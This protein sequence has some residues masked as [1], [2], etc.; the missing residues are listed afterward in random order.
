VVDAEGKDMKVKI[1]RSRTAIVIGGKKAKRGALKVGMD[2]VI[3]WPKV[4][5]ETKEVSCK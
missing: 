2:C 3:T 1:S 4:N 5:G